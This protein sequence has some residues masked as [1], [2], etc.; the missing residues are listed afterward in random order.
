MWW[1]IA[2]VCGMLIWLGIA[3][4]VYTWWYG[5]WWWLALSAVVWVLNLL[6]VRYIRCSDVLDV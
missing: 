3:A 2:A 5:M 4:I 6:V 1:L